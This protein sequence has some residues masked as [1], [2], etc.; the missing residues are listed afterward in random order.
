[1]GLN[2]TVEH[3]CILPTSP[4]VSLAAGGVVLRRNVEC[5]G[6]RRLVSLVTRSHFRYGP[7]GSGRGDR[8]SDEHRCVMA[9][10]AHLPG[11]VPRAVAL[12]WVEAVAASYRF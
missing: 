5:S 12:V 3:G 8:P 2:R 9:G 1:M 7:G 11:G 10:T 4:E 6:G